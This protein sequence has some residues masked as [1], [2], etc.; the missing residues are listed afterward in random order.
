MCVCESTC[1]KLTSP[2]TYEALWSA[3]PSRAS[4]LC[5]AR[6]LATRLVNQSE[7]SDSSA[8]AATSE[9]TTVSA[10]RWLQDCHMNNLHNEFVQELSYRKQIARKLRKQYVEG[11]YDNPVTLKSWLTVTQGHWKRNRWVDHTRLTTS[12]VI[13]RWILSWPLNVV[14]RS[15]KIIEI[16]VI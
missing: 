16:S 4:M 3:T 7:A 6:V 12:R 8:A 5:L 10:V 13:G 2:S 14:Q 1:V 15:V 9:Q 11:I